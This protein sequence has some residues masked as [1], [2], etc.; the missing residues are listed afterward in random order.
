[1]YDRGISVL[2][3]MKA[4]NIPPTNFTL[5]VLVKLANRSKKLEKAFTLCEEISAQYHFR[6]NVHVYSNL[7]NACVVNK[8]LGRAFSVFEKMLSERVRP[9]ARGYTILLRACVTNRQATDAAGLLRAA[10]G[11]TGVHPRLAEYESRLLQPQG[12]LP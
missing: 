6:L 7:I 5:S 8:D 2:E 9:D 10:V 1:M 11:V 12:G 4:A 3:S